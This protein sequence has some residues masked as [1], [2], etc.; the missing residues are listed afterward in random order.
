MVTFDNVKVG[1]ISDV[2]SFAEKDV[3]MIDVINVSDVNGF[4][5]N[6]DALGPSLL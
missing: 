3:L 5:K 2:I 1:K 4:C 6:V